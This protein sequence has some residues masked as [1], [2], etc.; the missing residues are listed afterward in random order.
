MIASLSELSIATLREYQQDAINR[1]AERYR[2]ILGDERGLGKTRVAIETIKQAVDIDATPDVLVVGNSAAV[3][4]WLSE[5]EKWWPYV[6]VLHY[7]GIKAKRDAVWSL[8]AGGVTRVVGARSKGIGGFLICTYDMLGEIAERRKF[9]PYIIY[10]ESHYLRNRNTLRYKNAKKLKSIGLFELT[11][12]P[13]VNSAMDLWA[14][15]H[16]LDPKRW[17]SFWRFVNDY[18]NASK[19]EGGH[20]IIG[21]LAR[22][23]RLRADIAP[24]FLRRTK[25]QVA[26]ELPE[27]QRHII[28]VEMSPEQERLYDEL[29]ERMIAEVGNELLLTPN[30]VALITRL[31]QILVT[32]ALVGG[33]N[34]SASLDMLHDLVE[35]DYESGN[36]VI[37]FTPF[38]DAFPYIDAILYALDSSHI[39]HIQGGMGGKKILETVE[40]FQ[41]LKGS[42]KALVCS[43][44]AATSFTATAA[45]SA[46]FIGEDWT[47]AVNLQAE[48]RIH[49]ISQTKNVDIYYMRYRDTISEY[50]LNDVNRRKM[51]ESTNAI[52]PHL[53][54]PRSIKQNVS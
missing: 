39:D 54:K 20:T 22:P 26:R 36:N 12:T 47:P 31:R 11:G 28:D 3:G 4:V 19:D 5:V 30:T 45:S 15:L 2:L 8:Y 51:I 40:Y 46:Y 23:T 34:D 1:L 32:P 27:K 37:I 16:L 35:I 9:W 13:I 42:R 49:R 52:D 17:S 33:K 14:Q 24:Y 18:M 50:I 53:L 44:R 10:D 38:V 48:D 7:G 29:A 6:P 25:S 21:G 43:V 41:Q